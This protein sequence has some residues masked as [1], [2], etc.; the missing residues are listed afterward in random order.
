MLYMLYRTCKFRGSLTLIIRSL[1]K[2]QRRN[3][4]FIQH[5][6]ISQKHLLARR[7]LWACNQAL[8]VWL[9]KLAVLIDNRLTSSRVNTKR[10]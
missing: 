8:P 9:L 3:V 5:L 2:Q 1:T 6:R 10:I 7:E 4:A